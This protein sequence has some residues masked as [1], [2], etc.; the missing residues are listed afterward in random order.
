PGAL[1][2]CLG[3]R[4]PRIGEMGRPEREPAAALRT[5]RGGGERHER[6]DATLGC[7]RA[8]DVHRDWRAR[9]TWSGRGDAAAAHLHG[10]GSRTIHI[11]DGWHTAGRSP[12]GHA[13]GRHTSPRRRTDS[14]PYT[15]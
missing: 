14:G 8:G 7:A 11:P 5:A 15:T 4:H 2:G 1:R 12:R 9:D 3:A 6:T 10:A 13:V